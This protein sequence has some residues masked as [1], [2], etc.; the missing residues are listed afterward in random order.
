MSDRIGKAGWFAAAIFLACIAT[1]LIFSPLLSAAVPNIPPAMLSQLKNMSPSE[2]AALAKQ[3]GIELPT[4]GGLGSQSTAEDLVGEPGEEVDVFE[5]VQKMQLE[6]EIRRRIAEE[7]ME[8]EGEEE[9][10]RFGLELFD[11]EV[12]P[13]QMVIS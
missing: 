9:L 7:Q 10:K 1:L 6:A 11:A 4:S 3:Y 12:S 8:E 2:Q 13:H 5:R